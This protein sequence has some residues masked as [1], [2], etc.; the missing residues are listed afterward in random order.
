MDARGRVRIGRREWIALGAI[1]VFGLLLR[2]AYLAEFKNSPVFEYPGFDAAFNDYWARCLVD[3]EY[4]APEFYSD[5]HIDETPFFRP[6][7]YPYF[8]AGLYALTGKSYLGARVLQM[9]LGLASCVLASLLGRLL[10]GRGVGL[11]FAALMSCYWIF[12]YFEGELQSPVL[13]VFLTLLAILVLARCRERT[14]YRNTIGAGVLIGLLA[15]AIPNALV[16]APV[17]GVWIWWIARRRRDPGSL[18]VALV[19]LPLGVVLAIAPVTIRNY[20]VARDFI[21]ITSNAGIN[22]Y[23]GNNEYTDC[24]TAS[25][26]ILGVY[27]GLGSWTCFDEPAIAAAVE[28]IAGRRLKSSEVSAYFTRKGLAHITS[29]PG[30]TLELAVRKAALFWGPAEVSNNE[31]LHFDRSRS[32]VLRFLPGFPVAL[33]LAIV[34]LVPLWRENR[35]ARNPKAKPAGDNF[36]HAELTALLLAFVVVYFASYLPFFA[37]GR[38]RVP[39]IPVLL[40]FGAY[41][42]DTVRSKISGRRFGE[43]AALLGVFVVVYLVARIQFAAYRPDLGMWHFLRGDAYRKQGNT[44][45]AQIEFSEAVRSSE[46]PNALAYNNLGVAFDRM[47]RNDEAIAQFNRALE[48]NPNYLDA[49]KNLVAILLRLK[50]VDEATAHLFEIVRLDPEDGASRFNLGVCLMRLSRYLEGTEHLAEAARLNP[51]YFNAQ[52]YLAKALALSGRLGEAVARYRVA[53]SLAENNAE[54]RFEF[55]E[56]L[57]RI[58]DRDEAAAQSRRVLE[59]KPDHEGAK[60]LLGELG[61]R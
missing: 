53:L 12:I 23:I 16:L 8:L 10:F 11:I 18:R 26:P 50:R 7:G 39:I 58:G 2:W 37:A 52:Y 55:A 29:H 14:T 3:G 9:I 1:L 47:G 41:G 34:G 30:R 38:Y 25:A 27:T 24:V 13:L 44:E 20:A 21:P 60:Q 45:L 19:G 35:A 43:A 17:A 5:P 49:R 36:R 4:P 51:G 31:V 46:E 59:T 33:A 57:A 56:L 6:P 48:I 42:I 15:L 61:T 40:L 28:K 54:V 22:F 32:R